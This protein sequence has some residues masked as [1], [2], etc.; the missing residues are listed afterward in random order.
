MLLYDDYYVHIYKNLR[1]RHTHTTLYVVYSFS[2]ITDLCAVGRS[3]IASGL[4][5]AQRP[6]VAPAKLIASVLVV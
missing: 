4:D 3:E 5:V 1:V 6:L 2:Q